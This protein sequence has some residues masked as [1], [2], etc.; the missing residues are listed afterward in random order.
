VWVLGHKLTT[1]QHK[2]FLAQKKDRALRHPDSTDDAHTRFA[3][4]NVLFHMSPRANAKERI[5]DVWSR[6]SRLSLALAT[7]QDYSF[8]ADDKAVGNI[9]TDAISKIADQVAAASRDLN[10]LCNEIRSE[11]YETSKVLY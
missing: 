11:E 2:E 9:G 6:L 3:L 10:A 1:R 4:N 7:F 8:Y 5:R